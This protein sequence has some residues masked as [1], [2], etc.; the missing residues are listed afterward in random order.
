MA[1]SCWHGYDFLPAPTA[2]HLRALCFR[3][4]FASARQVDAA[5]LRPHFK[6]ARFRRHF[7]MARR[8]HTTSPSR[9]FLKIRAWRLAWRT[10][11]AVFSSNSTGNTNSGYRVAHAS[12]AASLAA[13]RNGVFSSTTGI[14][15]N[16][17][18]SNWFLS[19]SNSFSRVAR[20]GA[21]GADRCSN[22]AWGMNLTGA[23]A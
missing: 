21:G 20:N 23:R 4:R 17:C 9:L 8:V 11:V 5:G 22:R 10:A 2:S 1:R 14:S 13:C 19:R 7:V 3:L 6:L 15:A 16:C 12:A 18:V